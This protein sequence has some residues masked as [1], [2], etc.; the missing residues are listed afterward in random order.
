MFFTH[1]AAT[2]GIVSIHLRRSAAGRTDTF[3]G[4]RYRYD[5]LMA[6][7][8]WYIATRRSQ[9]MRGN[10]FE[11][12]IRRSAIDPAGAGLALIAR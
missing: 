11:Q 7:F 10:F 1:C 2:L 8:K 4:E 3:L 12:M 9:L 6:E 5:A